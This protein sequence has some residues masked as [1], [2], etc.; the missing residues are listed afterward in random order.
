MRNKKIGIKFCG[1]CSPRKD[2]MELA[3]E[4]AAASETLTFVYYSQDTDVDG[5]L[6]L[7]A[8]EAA[9]AGI[10]DH[11]GPVILVTPQTVDHWPVKEEDLADYILKKGEQ[12]L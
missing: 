12:V 7:N 9:C 8:C 2:M 5:L 6:V 4:L 1:H 10:P 3:K 11:P